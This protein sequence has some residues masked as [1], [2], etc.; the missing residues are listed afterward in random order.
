MNVACADG[1][2]VSEVQ[3]VLLQ[4]AVARVRKGQTSVAR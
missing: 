1:I 4:Y 2:V 3:A